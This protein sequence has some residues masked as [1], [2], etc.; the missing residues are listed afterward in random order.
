MLLFFSFLAGDAVEDE[1]AYGGSTVS[2]ISSVRTSG[3]P[4]KK[5]DQ[6]DDDMKVDVG[7]TVRLQHKLKETQ[8]AKDKL[9]KRLEQFEHGKDPRMESNQ[10]T[11]GKMGRYL[12]K[13][14]S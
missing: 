1:S 9:E 13:K 11:P 4:E 3:V 6:D 7:L 12:L 2:G 5:A 10:H 14:S 8:L